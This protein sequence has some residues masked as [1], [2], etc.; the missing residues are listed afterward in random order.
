MIFPGWYGG[1]EGV[2][3][4]MEIKANS[5]FK[6]VLEDTLNYIKIPTFLSGHREEPRPF[7]THV[8]RAHTR[9][10]QIIYWFFLVHTLY[11]V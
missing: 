5:T 4:L 8:N 2:A 9:S 1:G 3:N 7:F 6:L 11:F 10:W